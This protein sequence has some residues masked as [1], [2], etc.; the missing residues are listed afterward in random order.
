M[1]SQAN[2]PRDMFR[3]AL[4]EQWHSRVDNR[5]PDEPNFEGTIDDRQ[6]MEAGAMDAFDYVWRRY[7]LDTLLISPGR[8]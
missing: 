8:E 6:A 5:F 4:E 3:W 1:A 7:G 2:K